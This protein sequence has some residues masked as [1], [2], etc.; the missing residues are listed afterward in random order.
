VSVPIILCASPVEKE[1][2]PPCMVTMDWDVERQN[3][4]YPHNGSGEHSK[5]G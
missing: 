1:S 5:L 4:K 3:L 2:D